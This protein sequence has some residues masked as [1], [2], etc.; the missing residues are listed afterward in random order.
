MEALVYQAA[1]NLDRQINI[2]NGDDGGSITQI[3]NFASGKNIVLAPHDFYLESSTGDL[4]SYRNEQAEWSTKANIGL[5]S[6][7]AASSY[8]TIGKFI[9]KGN[10]DRD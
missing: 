2:I 7:T 9:L 3:S 1:T 5:H 6:S 8:S 4:Y 10:K